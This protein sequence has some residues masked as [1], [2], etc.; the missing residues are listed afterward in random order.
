V[1]ASDRHIIHTVKLE[2]SADMKQVFHHDLQSKAG[3]ILR[4]QLPGALEPLLSELSDNRHI[5]FDRTGNTTGQNAGRP[6]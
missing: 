6:V 2:L 4:Q 3:H 5:V 1:S